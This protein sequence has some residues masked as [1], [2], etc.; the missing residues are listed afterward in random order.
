MTLNVTGFVERI[1]GAVTAS[2]GPRTRQRGI[3][4]IEFIVV[5]TAYLAVVISAAVYGGKMYGR[6]GFVVGLVAGAGFPFAI[7][8]VIS[9]LRRSAVLVSLVWVLLPL[10]AIVY[11]FRPDVLL[12]K[13]AAVASVIMVC[14]VLF[15]GLYSWTSSAG[16][17]DSFDLHFGHFLLVILVGTVLAVWWGWRSTVIVLLVDG[18]WQSLAGLADRRT[19][20]G[21]PPGEGEAADST[22][23]E[24]EA[25]TE[26]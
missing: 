21:L 13:L 10:L 20:A 1:V 18:A 4:A 24:T 3:A 15:Q 6:W 11:L 9:I 16:K 2:R 19:L 26:L 14:D 8:G 12:L 23:P 7:A 17:K 25:S 22:P 5:F